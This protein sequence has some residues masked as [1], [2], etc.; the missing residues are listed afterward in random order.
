MRRPSA[1]LR[2]FQACALGVLAL[3]MGCSTGA[4][5]AR[6]AGG[7]LVWADEFE[8][9][10]LSN[11][12]F[13]TGGHGWGNRELQYYTDGANAFIQYDEMAGSR[14]LVIEA[15]PGAPAGAACWYGACQYSSTRMV[16]RGKREFTHGRVE[17]R[18]RLPHTQGIWPA[19]WMLGSDFPDVGWP[20]SG[21][22]DIM[23]HVGFEPT[24]THGALHGPGYSGDR[25]F[26]GTH[27][28]GEAAD[29]RYHVY[30]VDWDADGL[31]WSVDGHEYFSLTRAKVEARGRWVFDQPFFLLLN[32][33]VGGDWPGNP[34]TGSVFPQRMYVDW[35]RVYDAGPAKPRRRNGAQPLSPPGAAARAAPSRPASP[36][37]APARTAAP[38]A[39]MVEPGRAL[40][41]LLRL[42]TTR[43]WDEACAPR[44]AHGCAARDGVDR[45]DPR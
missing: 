2:R 38:P 8:A 18:I 4:Q 28:L 12:S 43:A 11:W 41:P 24:L 33:A 40:R 5:T 30:A 37:A 44:D 16:T 21:E 32:V 9:A 7:Q 15:R 27:D 45:R 26:S 22:I 42:G 29:A 13:E 17:A 23:E 6:P 20:E 1:T 34:D 3:A 25:H 39:A 19:F 10:E 31:R 35:V 14:V 36:T